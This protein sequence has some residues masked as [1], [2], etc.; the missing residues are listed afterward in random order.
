MATLEKIRSKSVLL[1]IIIALALLAFI[2][3][4]FFNSS[5]TIFG[6]G[7]TVAKVDGEKISINELSAYTAEHQQQNPNI[8][9]AT[10][11]A[12]ALRQLATERLLAKEY[13]RLGLTVTNEELTQWML[14]S[15]S[16][17]MMQKN[18]QLFQQLG[19]DAK[20]LYDMVMNPSKYN[21]SPEQ[22]DALRRQ[23]NQLEKQESDFLLQTKFGVMMGVFTSNNL[24]L[25]RLYNDSRT[26]ASFEYTRY[27]YSKEDDK[28][29]KVCDEEINKYWDEHKEEYKLPYHQKGRSVSVI[30]VNVTPSPKDRQKATELMAKANEA[31]KTQEGTSG[32][33][34]MGD[35]VV[36]TLWVTSN[37]AKSQ[38]VPMEMRT[39]L[40]MLSADTAGVNAVVQLPQTS[41]NVYTLAKLLET[42]PEVDSI[43]ITSGLVP[44]AMATTQWLDSINAANVNLAALK[45][46]QDVEVDSMSL[47]MIELAGQ[48]IYDSVNNMPVGQFQVL[49]FPG[50]QT[51][52]G[53]KLIARVDRRSAPVTA[54]NIATVTYTLEPSSATLTKAQSDL[55]RYINQNNTAEQFINN[56]SKAGYDV[57]NLILTPSTPSLGNIRDT[58]QGVAWAF[59]HKKGEVSPLFTDETETNFYAVAIDDVYNNE[60]IPATNAELRK[61]ITEIL[62]NK[63]KGEA[64]AKRFKGKAQNV[65]GY[66][67]A[68]GGAPV[69]TGRAALLVPVQN[70]M[71]GQVEN[72]VTMAAV[73]G[74]PGTIAGPIAGLTD[75]WV[76]QVTGNEQNPTPYN[77]QQMANIYQQS[78]IG[79]SLSNPFDLLIG[80]KE[81]KDNS[82]E[83]TKD[84]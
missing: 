72:A 8:D 49:T 1:L 31:L 10:Q 26:L 35:L 48:P 29:Y 52:E 19:M 20:S 28:N 40:S 32:V 66:A 33:D 79:P 81:F 43:S 13:E 44:A 83:F 76:I 78:V 24:D 15:G 54:Y 23:W 53:Y 73:N 60:Y 70:P 38:R 5:R 34:A 36:S 63:K 82:L 12:M 47:S 21:L 22:A 55:A 69:T 4:D 74:K 59:K 84:E 39:A 62:V 37:S 45:G 3:T 25:K 64:L 61:N 7:T 41:P 68:F 80:N 9:G 56:A 77:A 2:L 65:Q 51:P 46:M 18:A 71:T 67:E 57:M 27:P 50:Q 75:L 6:T 17:V 11:Q 58:K 30:N 42:K 16:P 14:G